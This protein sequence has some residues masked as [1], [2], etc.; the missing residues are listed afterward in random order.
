M[1]QAEFK[2]EIWKYYR[3]HKRD[4]SWRRTTDPYRIVVSEIMLQQTQTHR[5]EPKFQ[6]FIKKFPNFRT[7]TKASVSEVLIA[8]QGLGYNRRG[9][10]LKK[11]A[12]I[13]MNE[14]KGKLP[15]DPAL[16]VKFPGIGPNTAGSI[17]AFAFNSHIVFIETNIRRVF[18]HFFF[19]DRADIH[20]RDIL[21]L[22]EQT[23]PTRKFREWY[24]ALMDYGA[25]LA[26]TIPNPN[27]RSKH[28]T[29]QSKFTGS[30]RQARGLILRLLLTGPKTDIVLR[31]QTGRETKALQRI[32]GSLMKEGFVLRF[33]NKWQLAA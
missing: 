13:V 22:V 19:A 33:R 29:V 30:D 31:K 2:K 20:D 4:F 25:M 17:A 3:T 15:S 23:L 14:Y 28:Y 21:A 5:V 6:N 11:I 12:E 26:K 32:L 9:L 8:W 7:L 24:F 18:I 16:L 10:Y 27:R 1:T